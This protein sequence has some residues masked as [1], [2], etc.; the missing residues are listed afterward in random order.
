VAFAVVEARTATPMLPLAIFRS[1]Q[2]SGANLTTMTVYAALNGAM[3][4]LAMQLQQSLHYSPLQA[5]AAM[6][7]VTVLMLVLS[8]PMGALAQRTGQRLPMAAGPVLAAAGLAL[9]ARITPGANYPSAVL[10]AVTVFGLGLAI[11]VAP[12]TAAVLGAL[13][14]DQ[15][16]LASGATNAVAVLPLLAGIGTTSGP[17]GPGFSRAKRMSQIVT[18]IPARS[19]RFHCRWPGQ[20]GGMASTADTGSAGPGASEPDAKAQIG[21]FLRAGLDNLRQIHQ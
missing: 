12:L 9:M 7:P 8:P 16:G 2:F 18:G 20:A 5:G 11:T 1:A 4:L 21:G 17:L 19:G 14:Q 10:P 13:S 15:A 6:L 3:F